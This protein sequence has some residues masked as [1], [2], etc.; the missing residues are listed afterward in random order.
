M[1]EVDAYVARAVVAL[2]VIVLLALAAWL[3]ARRWACIGRTRHGRH[4]ELIEVLPISVHGRLLVVRAG[5]RTFL[6]GVTA[7]SVSLLAELKLSGGQESLD[8]KSDHGTNNSA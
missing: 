4:L 5:E 1:S 2:L 8:S 3:A 7:Q 6:L